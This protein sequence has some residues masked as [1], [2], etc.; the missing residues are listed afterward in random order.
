M[1][2]LTNKAF[3]LA[4]LGLGVITHAVPMHLDTRDGL[5]ILKESAAE[6]AA[7]ALSEDSSPPGDD[8]GSDFSSGSGVSL[9][10]LNYPWIYA[11]LLSMLTFASEIAM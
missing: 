3:L 4:V 2:S 11:D 5:A 8:G 1:F 10:S 7:H 9:W 6:G